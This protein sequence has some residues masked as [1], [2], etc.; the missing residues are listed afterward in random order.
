[1]LRFSSGIPGTMTVVVVNNVAVDAR[2]VV[3]IDVERNFDV[4]ILTL[5]A[6]V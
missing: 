5:V 6:T 2:V 1:M 4:R 3:E